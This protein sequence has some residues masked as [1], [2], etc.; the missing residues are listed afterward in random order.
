MIG[1][2]QGLCQEKVTV[3]KGDSVLLK[4]DEFEANLVEIQNSTKQ[5]FEINVRDGVTHEWIKG[6]GLGP[7]G[8][9]VVDVRSGQLLIFTNNSKKEVEVE[10]NFVK[11]KA[12]EVNSETMITFTLRNSTAKSIPLIIPDVMNPNLTPFSSSGVSLKIG[13]EI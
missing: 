7:K 6:F 9:A 4:Y 3:Q 8:K 2:T 10:L 1:I 11:R 12:P 13:Q 5:G